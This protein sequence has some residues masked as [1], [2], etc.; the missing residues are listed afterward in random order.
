M[1]LVVPLWVPRRLVPRTLLQKNFI[2]ITTNAGTG[3]GGSIV[4]GV[5]SYLIVGGLVLL[6]L[7]K[8]YINTE[9]NHDIDMH[10]VS[11]YA[12]LFKMLSLA[13]SMEN[14]AEEEIV[15][16][17]QVIAHSCNIGY[18]T[19]KNLHLKT[20]NG[21]H[22]KNLKHLKQMI[23]DIAKVESIST[24]PNKIEDS[25]LLIPSPKV[26]TSKKSTKDS[27]VSKTKIEP[28]SG[29]SKFHSAPLVLEFS[30]GQIMVLDAKAALNA[31]DQV[32]F[33]CS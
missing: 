23:D 26:T 10:D 17:S 29:I 7:S 4:G 18:E 9:F 31:K 3:A 5:P 33:S 16:L 6:A 14:I 8:E 21:I 12:E 24:T 11:A 22:V 15:I 28:T 25:Q 19:A 20:F 27:K 32:S 30:N 2:D 1:D 13:D